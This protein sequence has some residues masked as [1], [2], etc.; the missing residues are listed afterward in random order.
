MNPL[1]TKTRTI[2]KTKPTLVMKLKQEPYIKLSLTYIKQKLK[3]LQLHFLVPRLY[4]LWRIG[5]CSIADL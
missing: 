3:L 5:C 4:P 1:E 2:H